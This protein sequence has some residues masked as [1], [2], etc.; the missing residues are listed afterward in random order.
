[1]TVWPSHV[2]YALAHK[3]PTCDADVGVECSTR[4][5]RL[6]MH[7]ARQDMGARHYS[8]DV[9]RAPL[10]KDREPDKRYDSLGG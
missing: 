9:G 8:D 10:P 7:A 1:M 3:C 4:K 5:P 2:E 6:R